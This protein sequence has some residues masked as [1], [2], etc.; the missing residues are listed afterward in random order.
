M[1]WSANA[2]RY[3]SGA[4]ST[5]ADSSVAGGGLDMSMSSDIDNEEYMTI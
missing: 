3:Y 1:R 4:V 2:K 5:V